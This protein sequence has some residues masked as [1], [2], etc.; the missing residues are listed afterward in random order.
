[1]HASICDQLV[2]LV[3][4]ALEAGATQ[5]TVRISQVAKAI[6]VS[7]EDDG[8][9]MSESVMARALDPFYTD[10]R[11]HRH[12]RVGLGLAFLK[13][14]VDAAGGRM[15]LESQPGRRTR[16]WFQLDAGHVDMPPEGDWVQTITGVMAF[17]GGYELQVVR[18]VNNA[19]YCIR[20]S[21]LAEAL[22]ELETAASLALVNDYVASQEEALMMRKGRR[23]NGSVDT[24][25]AAQ[26]AR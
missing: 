10:G 9:G 22:G 26:A 23:S 5:V 20:R 2:D 18:Q 21:E 8:C 7:V 14:M 24:G 3:Q 25:G 15:Q 6:E 1:M 4:N 17:Q 19:Q 12:R 16:V 11:K 13:Q